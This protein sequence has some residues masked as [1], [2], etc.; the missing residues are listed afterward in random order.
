[1]TSSSSFVF[2]FALLVAS[3]IPSGRASAQCY[4]PDGLDGLP[5]TTA[6]STLPAFPPALL[7][8]Q[9]ICW[10]G[11]VLAGQ[12]C[13]VVSLSAPTQLQCAEYEVA[14]KNE[15]CNSNLQL[16]GNLH[17]DYTRTWR[18]IVGTGSEKQVW[19]FVVKADLQRGNTNFGCNVPN[20]LGTHPTAFY[21]GY[22]D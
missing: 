1:M 14:L 7:P 5:C 16:F 4:Q 13:G 17:L 2:A 19:R 21:Y 18:E 15:D 9:S 20:C 11:C 10:D 22:L 12:G 3:L 6:L 8:A